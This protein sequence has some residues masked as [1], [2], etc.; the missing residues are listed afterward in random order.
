MA[1]F[2]R[3]AL[4][5]LTV[6]RSRDS[7]LDISIIIPIKDESAN[8]APLAEELNQVMESQPWS[9]ECIWVDDGSTD[10]SLDEIRAL[11]ASHP[12]HR[13]ISFDKNAGQ[14][15]A[16]WAGSKESRGAI[17]AT[18]DGDRQNDPAD[19]PSLIK[20][21]LES[22]EVDMVNGYRQKRQDNFIRK[23]SSKIA[24]SFRNL[25][26]GRSVRD[27]GCSTRAFRRECMENLPL[28]KGMHRF[29]PTLVAM[30]GLRLTEV[31]VKHR[32]RIRGTTKYNI[33]NRLWVGL[34][35]LFGVMW[36]RK[37]GLHYEIGLS[38]QNHQNNEEM[39]T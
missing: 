28:F 32:P 5:H 14:S 3:V 25:T 11:N 36:I 6:F 19:L 33:H 24:N 38:S 2:A 13:F 16:L 29:L 12:R 27:V 15:A 26:T 20:I 30:K 7:M 9:W 1:F 37:R 22:P 4:G 23:M 18:L 34:Y 21:L 17:I 31:P 35:D 39:R 8:I 10:G